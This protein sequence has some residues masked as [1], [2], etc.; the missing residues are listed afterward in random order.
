[1]PVPALA[2]WAREWAREGPCEEA[3]FCGVAGLLCG[4]V[5]SS[6]DR[7]WVVLEEVDVGDD[8][9]ERG[10]GFCGRLDSGAMSSPRPAEGSGA[11]IADDWSIELVTALRT[12]MHHS[13]PMC[14]LE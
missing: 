13:I 1:M 10:G 6:W 2:F 8:E 9:L 7:V 14:N 4:R 3:T 11:A 12:L 5:G